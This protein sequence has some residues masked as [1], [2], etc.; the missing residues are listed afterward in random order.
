LPTPK[1]E[2]EL[3]PPG[4]EKDRSF[5]EEQISELEE[6]LG[7]SPGEIAVVLQNAARAIW[8]YEYTQPASDS[9]I[10]T[11]LNNAAHHADLLRAR[12]AE[13]GPTSKGGLLAEYGR[14]KR[15]A[16]T[17]FKKDAA[18]LDRLCFNLITAAKRAKPRRGR[19]PNKMAEEAAHRLIRAYT[20][21]SGVPFVN[22]RQQSASRRF[23]ITALRMLLGIAPKTASGAIDRVMEADTTRQKLPPKVG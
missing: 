9:E 6:I 10:V 3:A 18:A 16:R 21:I 11:G 14:S 23:V 17:Q 19:P 7:K 5:T 12:I 1:F 13:L 15:F 8:M 2:P 4:Y 20:E 22:S